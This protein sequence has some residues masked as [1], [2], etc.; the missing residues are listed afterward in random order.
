MSFVR[1]KQLGYPLTG[2]FTGSFSGSFTGSFVGDGSGL[3]NISASNIVGLN[4]SQIASGSVTASISPNYGF[5]VNTS[6]SISS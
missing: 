5:N 4:L 6:A 2:S 1:S 3:T